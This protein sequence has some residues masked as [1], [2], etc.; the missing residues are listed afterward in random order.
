MEV[1]ADQE[2]FYVQ[3]G[4]EKQQPAIAGQCFLIPETESIGPLLSVFG[5]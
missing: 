4:F 5:L 1:P 2:V 3:T